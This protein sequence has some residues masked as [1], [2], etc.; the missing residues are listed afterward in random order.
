MS[1]GS[2]GT[3]HT[4]NVG[5]PAARVNEP[6]LAPSDSVDCTCAAAPQLAAAALP[7]I[8]GY[9]RSSES[10][11]PCLKVRAVGSYTPN[12]DANSQ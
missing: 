10:S 3:C 2:I 12:P 9:Y 11:S 7:P 4:V 8:L 5:M 6:S 1:A